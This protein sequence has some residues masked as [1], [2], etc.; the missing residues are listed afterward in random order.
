LSIK[1]ICSCGK[2]LRAR[3]AWAS[4]R[5]LCPKCGNPVGVPSLKPHH[6]GDLGPMTPQERLRYAQKRKQMGE[7]LTT[8]PEAPAPAAPAQPNPRLVRMLSNRVKRPPDPGTRHLERHWYE[9]LLYPLRA[10]RLCLGLA[11]FLAITGGGCALIVPP[12]L[13]DPE[14]TSQTVVTIWLVVVTLMIF[15]L[16]CSFLECVVTSAAAGE[17]YYIRWSGNL[18]LTV[19]FSGAKWLTCFLAGPILFAGTAVVY[20]LNCGEPSLLD[21]L[22]LA[23]LGI[24]ANGYWFFALLSVTDRGRLRDANPIAVADLVHRLGWQG[25]V[26]SLLAAL[27]LLAHGLVVLYGVVQVHTSTF[28]GLL[29]LTATWASAVFWSTFFCRLLGVWCHRTRERPASDAA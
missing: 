20:W 16:P 9:C 18:V 13:N 28:L 11:L 7:L 21:L 19:L 15:G 6:L 12:I 29:M 5:I 22:I 1:F 25:L 17:V 24:V 10:F 26:V 2:K 8:E 14:T 3:D 4:R 27:L 23:E